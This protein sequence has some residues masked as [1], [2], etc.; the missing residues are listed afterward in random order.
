[1][2]V[3]LV[4]PAPTPVMLVLGAFD[5]RGNA[6]GQTIRLTLA[7]GEVRRSSVGEL[8]RIVVLQISPQPL[9]SGY[10]RIREAQGA[11]FQVAGNVEIFAGNTGGKRSALLSP[12]TASGATNW[13]IPFGAS[14]SPYYTG[15]AVVN[16]NEL[17]TVQTDVTVEVIGGDGAVLRRT[18]TSLSPR[19]RVTGILPL[20]IRSGYLRIRSNLPVYVMGSIGT[21]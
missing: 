15:Y 21:S 7:P 10:I 9:I 1:S 3:N 18:T 5:D 16:A 11:S 2:I 14:A 12:I 17:L 19:Y 20:G 4:N 13:L 6:I 8:F